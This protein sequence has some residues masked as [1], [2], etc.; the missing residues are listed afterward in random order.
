MIQILSVG[1]AVD[2]GAAKFQLAHAALELVGGA[3]RVLHRQVRKAGIA[4][5]AF[6]DF[7]REKIV[8][9]TR[10]AGGRGDVALDLDAGAGDGQHR[11]RDAGLVHRLQALLAEIGQ[12]RQQ[13]GGVL[14]VDIANRGPPVSLMPGSQKML[15]QRN[16]L[17]HAF[18]DRFLSTMRCFPDAV[19]H[20]VVH[21]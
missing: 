8:G 5:R 7:A 14:R 1:V 17:H 15:F 16:F 12:A 18:L 4:V 11:A 13:I 20:E 9:V 3:P 6:A 10:D 19:Q 21:R 2:H